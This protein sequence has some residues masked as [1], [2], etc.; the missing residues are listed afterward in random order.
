MGFE[1]VTYSACFLGC[2]RRVPV[3]TQ[4]VSTHL[5][6]LAVPGRCFS[7]FGEAHGLGRHY[8]KVFVNGPRVLAR[9]K[10]AVRLVGTVDECFRDEGQPVLVRSALK[11][12]S[13]HTHER[14]FTRRFGYDARD[15]VREIPV[16][17]G[18]VVQG[19][20]WFDMGKARTKLR[21]N[22]GECHRHTVRD[23]VTHRQGHRLDVSRVCTARY[24]R[25]RDDPQELGVKRGA[26][27]K[28]GIQV[29]ASHLQFST[30]LFLLVG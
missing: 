3:Y 4:R 7:V 23:R 13:G 5:Y 30:L 17:H 16:T 19:P 8:R 1:Y 24:V 12:R 29:N 9:H 2:A 18:I 25:T 27:A 6:G 20:V 21:R 26:F 15:D 14:R 10:R 28:V 22:V 11:L